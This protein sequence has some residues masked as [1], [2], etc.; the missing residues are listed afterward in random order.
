MARKQIALKKRTKTNKKTGEIRYP[1]RKNL[2]KSIVKLQ[3]ARQDEVN[4]RQY[5]NHKVSKRLAT[6]FTVI[7]FEK[8]DIKAMTKQVVENEDGTTENL[9]KNKSDLNREM[10]RL[11]IGNIIALTTWKAANLGGQVQKVDPRHTS[12]RCSKCGAIHKESRKSQAVYRCIECGYKI[13]ADVNAAINI[14]NRKPLEL[15]A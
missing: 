12:Q 13:N 9:G 3:K 11:G 1:T 6:Y 4:Y 2:D 15:A 8:L 5:F 14:R 10:L 7:K